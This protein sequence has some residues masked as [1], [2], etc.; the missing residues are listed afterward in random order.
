VQQAVGTGISRN[1]ETYAYTVNGKQA[2]VTD[3]KGNKTGYTYDG[4]DR[5]TQWAFPSPTSAGTVSSTDHEDYTYDANGNRLTLRKRDG[6]S[7]SF[8]YDALNRMTVKAVPKTCVSG[9]SCT[10]APASALRDVYY[11]YDSRGL[12]LSA[13]FDSATGTDAVL[14]AYDNATRQTSSNT[15]MGGLSYTLSYQYDADGNRTRV[16]YP[17]TNYFTY[18]Y[19][20]LDRP[21][22]I[23]QSGSTTIATEAWDA[24]G[25]RSAETRGAVAI[26][27]GYDAI[28][29]LASLSNDLAGTGQDVTTAL[30]YTPASE[31]ANETRSNDAYAWTAAVSVN[32]AYT[33]NGLNQYGAI[34]GTAQ[35]YDSNGSLISSGGVSYTYDA[36]NRLVAASTGA[37]LVYDPM[38]RLF[39]TAGG[40][41]GITQFLYDGDA[42]V[43]EYNGSG[44]LLRRYV[45][46]NDEDDPMLWYEGAGFGDMRSLQVD[47]Q[48]SVVSIAN[49]AGTIL[50]IDSYDEYGIPGNA[51]AGR[52]QYTG[53][54]WIPELGL[55][56]YKARAYSPTLGRFLQIDPVGYKDNVNLYAY[57]ANDPVN[58]ADPTG[59][60]PEEPLIEDLTEAASEIA[61]SPFGQAVETKV[62]AAEEF[63][64]I[65][66][67]P[68]GPQPADGEA[69]EG[70]PMMGAE[71]EGAAV[72]QVYRGSTLARNMAKA[73]NPVAKGEEEAHHLVAQRAA[74]AQPARDVLQRVGIGI[75]DAENGAAAKTAVH[76]GTHTADYYGRVNQA[77]QGAENAGKDAV[78]SV[79][80]G[81]RSWFQ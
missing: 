54:A 64:G 27:Y 77:M 74:A 26:G 69:I 3:A 23:Q 22:A 43:A 20:G 57:V 66:S 53:Q 81:I 65:R 80:D 38:G 21:T 63:V 37:S 49:S 12:Q 5:L 18:V 19:D 55:Y 14:S 58:H 48:G 2:A 35:G 10:A 8:T 1:Y 50:N 28:S 71:R 13:R 56:H 17:D 68:S 73:G 6:R 46:G 7:F 62:G 40:S 11:N 47:D 60:G 42:I 36:E 39:Q 25:R 34:A 33:P 61:E 79:L 9:Y 78:I 4:F 45:H 44:A 76:A 24:Q 67:T 52:F 72:Q 70:I 30:T 32:R 41:A 75:H 31:V 29:R 59:N 15:S 16:T 51:N